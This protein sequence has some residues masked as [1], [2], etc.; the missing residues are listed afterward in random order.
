[1]FN[2][3]GFPLDLERIISYN[4]P[5]VM[6]VLTSDGFIISSF[7]PLSWNS[8][9]GGV[10]LS[11]NVLL[12][13][14]VIAAFAIVLSGCAQKQEQ[15]ERPKAETEAPE[16]KAEGSPEAMKVAQVLAD[17][18][19]QDVAV[20]ETDLGNIFFKFYEEDAPLHAANFKKLAGEGFYDGC[21]F[22]RIIPGFVIQGGDPFSK[23]EDR[24]DDGTGGPGYTIPA[25]IK[26]QHTRG[27]VAAARQGDQV[28]P[29][30]RSSGSQFYICMKELPNLDRGGYSVYGQV[31]E[32]M[33]V[34]DKIVAVDRD[35]RDNP[36]QKIEMKKVYI[37]SPN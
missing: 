30:K 13:V 14:L 11:R 37:V 4:K 9:K 21:S 15:A 22:H 32:G 8:S 33:D 36:L 23:D 35:R 28:N 2:I 20:I 34:A 29:E 24:S 5:T 16:K 27:S 31:V 18:L 6:G 3:V 10:M 19:K 12:S 25:E 17:S 1:M 26:V 7:F